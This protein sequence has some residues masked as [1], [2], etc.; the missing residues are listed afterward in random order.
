MVVI[1]ESKE[2]EMK[3]RQEIEDER[4]MGIMVG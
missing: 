1:C 3:K 4:M 2:R